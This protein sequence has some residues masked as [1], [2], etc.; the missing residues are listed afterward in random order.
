M[1]GFFLRVLRIFKSV[2]GF[3]A[4]LFLTLI[5]VSTA[6]GAQG[7]ETIGKS[8]PRVKMATRPPPQAGIEGSHPEVSLAL[9]LL[10]QYGHRRSPLRRPLSGD[11][12]YWRVLPL[13]EAVVQQTPAE[14]V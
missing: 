14:C 3:L 4:M 9:L 6:A 11:E 1:G 10:G 5:P 8:A 13:L 2:G 7:A 12:R